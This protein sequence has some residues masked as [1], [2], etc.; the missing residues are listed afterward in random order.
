M[1][2]GESGAESVA[3]AT[4]AVGSGVDA[5]VAVGGDG[6]VHCAVQAVAGT[7]VPLGIVPAGGGNDLAGILG[8]PAD[9]R[10]T[11]SR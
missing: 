4:D 9:P 2:S 7:G 1:L 6:L 10:A 11:R 8:L 3:L 5:V